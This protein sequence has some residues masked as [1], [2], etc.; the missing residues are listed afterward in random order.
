MK[1]SAVPHRQ[2]SAQW[3]GKWTWMSWGSRNQKGRV[4]GCRG[5]LVRSVLYISSP[6]KV[7]DRCIRWYYRPENIH[8]TDLY[9]DYPGLK[10]EFGTDLYSDYPGLKKEFGTDLYSDY[11]GIKKKRVLDRSVFWLSRPGKEIWTDLYS[12]YPGLKIKMDRSVSWQSKPEKE[13]STDLCSDY[14]ALEKEFLADL[15]SD[16]PSLEN[17]FWQ[18]HTVII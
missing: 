13:F 10:K 7:F 18:I 12:D 16:F 2:V 9:A 15:Y 5:H 6:E 8:S 4:P 17:S 11:P 1:S 14:P 3:R